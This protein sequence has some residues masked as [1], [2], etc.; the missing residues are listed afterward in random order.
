M[1]IDPSGHWL[2]VGNQKSGTVTVFGIDDT[3]GK[4]TPTMQSFSV[5][6]A[7]NVK[8]APPNSGSAQRCR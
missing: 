4:L 1:G 5:G 3:T 2:I 8:F 7:V 6:S